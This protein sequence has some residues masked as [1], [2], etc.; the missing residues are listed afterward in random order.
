M[1]QLHELNHGYVRRGSQWWASVPI[2][3]AGDGATERPSTPPPAPPC[4]LHADLGGLL[5]AVPILAGLR[6]QLP[7]DVNALVAALSKLPPVPTINGTVSPCSNADYASY[8][9]N[10]EENTELYGM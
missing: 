7:A 4:P 6:A 5:F 3:S 8:G 10:N 2:E 1:A 9:A